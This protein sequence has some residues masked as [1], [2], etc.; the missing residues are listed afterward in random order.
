MITFLV[1]AGVFCVAA[2]AMAVGVVIGNRR[3]KGSCG[4][5]NNFRDSVGNPICDACNEPSPEC[6]GE[7]SREGVARS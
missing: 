3:I 2:A 7:A 5:L 1:T 6:A 4:G